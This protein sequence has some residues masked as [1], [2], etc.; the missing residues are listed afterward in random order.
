MRKFAFFYLMVEESGAISRAVPEHV[1]YWETHRPPGYNGGP[2]TD[3]SGGLIVFEASDLSSAE[4]IVG[5]DP[6]VQEGLLAQSWLK[7]WG[8]R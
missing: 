7:E 2:F 6:F 8:A 1:Q 5:G 3:R 4:E